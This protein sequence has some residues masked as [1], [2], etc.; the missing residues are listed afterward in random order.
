[1]NKKLFVFFV[2]T[3][4]GVAALITW[5]FQETQ[6]KNEKRASKIVK[7]VAAEDIVSMLKIGGPL[8]PEKT[9]GIVATAESRKAFLNTLREYFALAA[10]ARR[11]GLADSP[12]YDLMLQLKENAYL[13]DAYAFKLS[14]NDPEFKRL[15]KEDLDAYL[16]DGDHEKQFNAEIEAIYTIQKA[17][18]IGMESPQGVTPKP[19]GENL[20][21]VRQQWAWARI[22]SNMARADAEFMQDRGNQLRLKVI[23]ASA[24]SSMVLAKYWK[25]RIKP[26][27]NDIAVFLSKH[28]EF[29]IRKKQEQAEAIL[30]RIKAGE[31]FE[32][33]AKQY[34]EDRSTRDKG[35]LY[36][37]QT[38]GSG[39]WREV[40]A[41]VLGMENGQVFD[42]VVEANDGFHVVK[43][44]NKR[45]SKGKDGSNSVFYDFRHILFQRKFEDP[46]V[47][48]TKT[49]IPPPFMLPEEI[50]KASKE[51]EKRQIFVNEVIESE[52][53]VLPEDFDFE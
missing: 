36:T 1:M 7:S 53:I 12:E 10:R 35:G 4:I 50:A 2:A 23:D 13:S 6:A 44:I 21:R 29:D 24:L 43:L 49:Q 41:A 16:A 11:E 30:K 5:K 19:Y 32:N 20:E 45:L 42:R 34:S 33:L 26:N 38:E 8:A 17:S 46:T 18:A 27:G 15:T 25:E 39:I 9:A 47:D 40:E 51:K 52:A 37:D 14:S 31:S 48:R 28:P 3:V 22:Y